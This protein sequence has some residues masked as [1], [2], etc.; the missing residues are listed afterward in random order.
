MMLPWIDWEEWLIIN[1]YMFSSN[2]NHQ[3]SG[4]EC[5]ALWRLRGK[6]PHSVES[7]AQ[8]LEVGKR[9]VVLECLLKKHHANKIEDRILR[10]L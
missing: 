8:L 2:V 7:T 5:V 3:I 6:L 10:Y 9:K 4:L 1:N